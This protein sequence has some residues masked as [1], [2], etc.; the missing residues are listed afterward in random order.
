MRWAGL[1]AGAAG[2]ATAAGA[3]S[4]DRTVLPVQLPTPPTSNVLDVRDVEVPPRVEVTAP[5]GAPNVLVVLIDDMGFGASA[6]FGGPIAMPVA[7]QL[8]RQGIR[9]N[10]F[11]TTAICSATRVALLTGRNHHRN[12]MGG[13]TEVA[14][15]M[16][17]NTGV[18][19]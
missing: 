2:L 7:E 19:P 3:Q 10:Q 17:G 14:T 13:I 9:F 4:L 6:A 15:A 5:R 8:A 11:H 18:R 16:P 12:N 1:L